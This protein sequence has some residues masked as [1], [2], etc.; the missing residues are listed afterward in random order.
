MV[1]GIAI[2]CNLISVISGHAHYFNDDIQEQNGLRK[3]ASIHSAV[4][5]LNGALKASICV[6]IIG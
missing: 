3:L 4:P 2:W 1:N 6:R 5:N